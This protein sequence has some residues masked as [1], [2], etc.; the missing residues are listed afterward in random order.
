MTAEHVR[1]VLDSERD[2]ESFWR[3]CE[4]FARA[5][6][7]D[8]V[9]L[10][11]GRMTALQKSSGGVRG[12]V[13]GDFLR[14]LVAR[15]L[16]QQ[17]APAVERAT[18]PFQF[19]LTTKSGCECVAHIAQT[20]TDLDGNTPLLSVDGIGAFN[21][22]SRSAMLQGLLEVEGGSAAFPFVR[23]FYGSA[24]TY[25]WDDDEGVTHEVVQGEGGEQ[26]DP[27]MPALYAI[28]QH[29][30]LF[31][32]RD[33][34]LTTERLLAFLGDLYVLCS[35]HHVADVH[36]VLQQALWEHS[37]ISV[38]HGKIQIWGW[39]ALTVAAR[40]GDK[41][42]VVWRGDPS[43]PPSAQGVKVLGTPL[44]HEEIVRAQLR[45]STAA[46]RVLMQ[47]ISSIPDLQEAWLL[48]LF[49]AGSRANYLLRVVPPDLAFDFA[50]EHDL[51]LRGCLS[52]I[53]GCEVPNTSWEVANLPFS[54]RGVGLRSAPRLSTAAYW[55]SWADCLH[56]AQLRHPQVCEMMTTAPTDTAPGRK[57]Q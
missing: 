3:M 41:E 52:E 23:Q 9:V 10:R 36:I 22:I 17:L 35:P 25:W 37:R 29:R 53:L 7:S 21:L 5:G 11:M 19:A 57:Q 8:E 30:A 38:H 32:I 40:L 16:A 33:Q 15:T 14:R 51:A 2:G 49:C 34:L 6:T 47:R 39:R 54:I 46:Q 31:A 20:L 13:V 12:I 1:P 24:S 18:S 27:L 44:G 45:S 50:A 28:G 48:L 26:G 55:A 43:L 56:T 42:A 4:E